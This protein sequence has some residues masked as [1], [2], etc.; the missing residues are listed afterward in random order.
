MYIASPGRHFFLH[1]DNFVD[2]WHRCG[3]FLLLQNV[4]SKL[5]L[6]Q[7]PVKPCYQHLKHRAP[8]TATH[9]SV[10]AAATS[11]CVGSPYL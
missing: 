10:V 9:V 11:G 4:S 3:S 2:K 5:C 7:R 6:R 1:G 8:P